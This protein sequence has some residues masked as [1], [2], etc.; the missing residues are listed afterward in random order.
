MLLDV[1]GHRVKCAHERDLY[2]QRLF[3]FP[4]HDQ[5]HESGFR[6]LVER[7][8]LASLLEVW[9]RAKLKVEFC[10]RIL[11]VAV[12]ENRENAAQHEGALQI[13]DPLCE[14]EECARLGRIMVAAVVDHRIPHRGDPTLFWDQRNWCAMSKRCHDRKTARED[15]GF[16]NRRAQT[17][18]EA[19]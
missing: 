1:L 14:C 15:G 13:I 17:A 18:Q 7:L 10:I 12:V 5:Q 6:E 8:G 19:L 2:P 16:G 4:P 3:A 11:V 9:L